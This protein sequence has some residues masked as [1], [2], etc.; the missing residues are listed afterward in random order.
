MTEAQALLFILTSLLVI[1]AP[2]QDMIL[3][4]SRAIARSSKAGI[5]TAAGF[6]TLRSF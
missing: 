5:T 6:C 4:M 1:I 2:G 3:V